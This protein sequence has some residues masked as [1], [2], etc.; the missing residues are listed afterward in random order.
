M[1]E[2]Y[3]DSYPEQ[4]YVHEF[5]TDVRKVVLIH[6]ELALEGI[7]RTEA[8]EVARLDLTN[9]GQRSVATWIAGQHDEYRRAAI[10]LALV[11]LVTR[12]HHWL[13]Y[14]ANR[15]RGD[16]NE[17]FDRSVAQ[18]M[19]F[20]NSHLKNSPHQPPDFKKWVDVRDSV[21]HADSRASWTHDGK[22]RSIEPRFVI[23]GD[24]LNFTE[25][26][27]KEAFENMLQAIDWYDYQVEKWVVAKYGPRLFMGGK[28]LFPRK[29]TVNS[30]IHLLSFRTECPHH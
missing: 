22:P 23:S 2:D 19:N 6:H 30:P 17:T 8:E 21:I 1:D 4:T 12:F 26:D 16:A 20:L 3:F 10:N 14:L 5:E 11:G 15:I 18:E 7:T 9:E 28:P 29:Q 24:E 13:A 27:L 25:A